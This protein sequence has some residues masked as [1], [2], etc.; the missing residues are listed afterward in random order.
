MVDISIQTAAVGQKR[1]VLGQVLRLCDE[2]AF[3][4][5][6][7]ARDPMKDNFDQGL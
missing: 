4:A 2:C 5:L 1:Q 7:V 6:H 3:A